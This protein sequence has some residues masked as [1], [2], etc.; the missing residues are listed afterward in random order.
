MQVLIL[1]SICPASAFV[2]FIAPLGAPRGAQAVSIRQHTSAQ[3][4]VGKAAVAGARM[5]AARD[6][7]T[8][9]SEEPACRLRPY[10]SKE[11]ND[12]LSIATFALG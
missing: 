1:S 2:T 4:E 10:K 8:N 6:A 11:D 7:I 3:R 12:G 9:L 5:S